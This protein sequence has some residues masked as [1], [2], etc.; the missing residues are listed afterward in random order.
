MCGANKAYHTYSMYSLE[1]MF[2]SPSKDI[3]QEFV[4]AQVCAGLFCWTGVMGLVGSCKGLLSECL[5]RQRSNTAAAANAL[6]LKVRR[7][8]YS[9]INLTSADR[10]PVSNLACA[11]RAFCY[12]EETAVTVL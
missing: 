3:V 5:S 6:G 11:C 12:A 8:L 1:P 7:L 2:H 10:M 4:C 9:A